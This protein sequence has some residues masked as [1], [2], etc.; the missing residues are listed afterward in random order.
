MR[1]YD[2]LSTKQL[3]SKLLKLEN[4]MYE[5]ARNLEFEDAAKLRDQIAQFKD[6]FFKNPML[7]I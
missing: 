1:Q 7:S 4:Q 3:N 5:H 6:H 2:Q